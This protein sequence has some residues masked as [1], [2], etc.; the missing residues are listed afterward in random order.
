M[1]YS[2]QLLHFILLA[3]VSPVGP[4]KFSADPH[5]TPPPTLFWPPKSGW[6]ASGTSEIACDDKKFTQIGSI[7]GLMGGSAYKGSPC[8]TRSAGLRTPSGPR[9][10]M[11]L[12]GR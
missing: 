6:Q 3:M 11:K 12:G 9:L 1:R 8:Y 10:S 4:N 2:S 5:N 7:P